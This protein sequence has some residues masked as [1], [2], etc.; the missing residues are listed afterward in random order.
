MICSIY[1]VIFDVVY[2][3]Y[4]F[5]D[6]CFPCY[7]YSNTLLSLCNNQ[8][9]DSWSPWS[10]DVMLILKVIWCYNYY[11]NNAFN[12]LASQLAE[13]GSDKLKK[14]YYKC[15]QGIYN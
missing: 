7:V 14:Y 5:Y 4:Y 10:N 2:D 1:D 11:I 8:S 13:I 3:Q 9:G 15:N 12:Q 6:L